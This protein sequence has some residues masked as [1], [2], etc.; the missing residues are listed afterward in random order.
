MRSNRH[1]SY[2]PIDKAALIIM[3][4]MYIYHLRDLNKYFN[5]C[6][7]SSITIAISLIKII[8]LF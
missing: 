2:L 1:R 8:A 6:F 4:L 7:R 3:E 5:N